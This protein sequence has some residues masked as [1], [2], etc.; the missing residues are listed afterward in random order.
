MPIIRCDDSASLHI[1]LPSSRDSLLWK[2]VAHS[3]LA[4]L[5]GRGHPGPV[6][7]RFGG[8]R[9]ACRDLRREE[10]LVLSTMSE[11]VWR[12]RIQLGDE[13][14]VY[15]DATYAGLGFELPFTLAKTN[16]TGPDNTTIILQTVDVETFSGYPGH[17]LTVVLFESDPSQ[18]FHWNETVLA[19]AQLTA[20]DKNHKEILLNLAGKTPPHFVS[21]RVRVDTDVPPGLY[22]DFL[23]TRLLNRS[24]NFTFVAS[25]GFRI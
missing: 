2:R 18:Q 10:K 16:P 17:L 1:P 4:G 5:R 25:L 23:V 9:C 20:A 11:L 24:Q 12:G 19:T 6:P 15:G 3:A 8:V 7:K 22:D 13:P 14:G 21:L